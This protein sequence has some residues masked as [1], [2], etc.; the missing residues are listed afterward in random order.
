MVLATNIAETSLTIDGICYVVDTGFCKQKSYNPRTGMESLI[1]TPVSQAAAEQ[2]K[3][4]ITHM[5]THMLYSSSSSRR[6]APKHCDGCLPAWL[7]YVCPFPLWL[8]ECMDGWMCMVQGR[9]GR[10]QDGKCFRLYT[11]WAFQNELDEDTVPEIQRTNMGNVVLMLMSLGI[12]NILQV[13]RGREG[14]DARSQPP[15]LRGCGEAWVSST[16]P[17]S[18]IHSFTDCPHHTPASA[19]S[20]P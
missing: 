12:N 14:G 20:C 6:D 10:T 15:W 9:A 16:P 5:H 18:F 8:Y 4:R 13:G 17:H 11:M 19:R 7:T 1:V 2:R 3:A